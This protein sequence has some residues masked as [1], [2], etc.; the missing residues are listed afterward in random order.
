ML[1]ATEKDILM[2]VDIASIMDR[3]AEC[4][5]EMSTHR[6]SEDMLLKAAVLC[7]AVFFKM[8]SAD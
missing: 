1:T 4:T 7:C 6:L 3:L 2:A 5:D 8:V